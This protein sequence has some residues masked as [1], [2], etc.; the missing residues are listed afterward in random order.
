MRACAVFPTHDSPDKTATMGEDEKL[1][2][3]M[4]LPSVKRM[5]NTYQ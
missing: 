2:T 1:F 5:M 3:T 4:H